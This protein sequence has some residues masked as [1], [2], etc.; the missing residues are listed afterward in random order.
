MGR[1]QKLVLSN[2]PALGGCLPSNLKVSLSLNAGPMGASQPGATPGRDGG[3]GQR[4]LG[5][6][7]TCGLGA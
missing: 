7:A 6:L 2:N 1:L 5:C 4:L 3:L